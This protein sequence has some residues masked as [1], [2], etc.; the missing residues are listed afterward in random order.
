MCC[1]CVLC[2][3][4]LL[5]P[6]A[7]IQDTIGF[8]NCSGCRITFFFSTLV[9]IETIIIEGM[10]EATLYEYPPLRVMILDEG[11]DK[12]TY[13]PSNFTSDCFHTPDTY[14]CLIIGTEIESVSSV[15][16]ELESYLESSIL[17]NEIEFY[18]NGNL[19][20]FQTE[21]IDNGETVFIP[22]PIPT[23]IIPTNVQTPPPPQPPQNQNTET[24]FPS[25]PPTAI[26]DILALSS[27]STIISILLCLTCTIISSVSIFLV[28]ICWFFLIKYKLR[29]KAAKK[30]LVRHKTTQDVLAKT[31]AVHSNQ[32]PELVFEEFT[33]K[34]VIRPQMEVSANQMQAKPPL[35]NNHPPSNSYYT[36][37]R[38]YE[39]IPTQQKR[40]SKSSSIYE[41][42]ELNDYTLES[43]T[44]LHGHNTDT[45]PF[46]KA[47]M[48][49]SHGGDHNN[50]LPV[51]EGGIKE[52]GYMSMSAAV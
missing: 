44:N 41:V 39:A 1:N 37:E 31:N 25:L 10:F 15:T 51:R 50:L 48:T 47:S 19:L 4:T 42:E 24:T 45:N 3:F 5:G 29:Y 18:S 49:S 2:L 17:L 23:T 20:N 9:S 11:V 12:I 35:P 21:Q 13:D 30:E 14:Y 52:D 16:I 33:D 46:S 8:T 6:F 27:P 34:S 36:Q 26:E 43:Y 40:H 32:Y 28:T 38:I 22:P 7:T